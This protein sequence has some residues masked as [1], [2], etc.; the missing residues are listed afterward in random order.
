MTAKKNSEKPSMLGYYIGDKV[1]FIKLNEKR[2]EIACP[3]C[4]GNYTITVKGVKYICNECGSGYHSKLGMAYK[5][6]INKSIIYSGSISSKAVTKLNNNV[7]EI[8]Y[9]IRYSDEHNNKRN[10]EVN[11]NLIF[12]NES[13]AIEYAKIIMLQKE[14]NGVDIV[15][16]KED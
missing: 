13:S 4:K 3:V 1:F 6:A 15:I 12:D 8:F 11:L 14:Y 10:E 9:N 2:V 5:D 16:N 7:T